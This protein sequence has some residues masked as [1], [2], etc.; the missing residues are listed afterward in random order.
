[1]KPIILALAAS[2]SLT[3]LAGCQS[4]DEQVQHTQDRKQDSLMKQ[5]QKQQ[6]AAQKLSGQPNSP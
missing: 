2:V 3:L 1:M 5:M 4:E 6:A